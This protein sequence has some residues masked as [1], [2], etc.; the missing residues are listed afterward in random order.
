MTKMEIANAP[1]HP[2]SYKA[3]GIVLCLLLVLTGATIA[4]SRIHLG[5]FNIWAALLIASSKCSLVIFFFM[6]LKAENRVIKTA[7][8]V[9]LFCVALVISFIFWD[10]FYRY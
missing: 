1:S 5:R 3:L 10:I 9:T 8:A 7:F 4:I 2:M 6:H